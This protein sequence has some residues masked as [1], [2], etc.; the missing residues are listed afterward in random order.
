MTKPKIDILECTLRDG[1]YL[2]DYQFTA[3]D[4]ALIGASLEAAGFRF[5]E[6]G[7][8]LGFRG[9]SPQYGIAAASDEEYLS[10]AQQ[11]FRKAKFGM[12]CIPGI[13]HLKDLDKAFK[14][15]MGFVRVG[16]NVTEARAAEP[17][18]KKAKDFGLLTFSNL[19]KSYALSPAEFAKQVQLVA[20]Y[21]AD[22]I[23]VV[24]SAGGMLPDQVK[25]YVRVIKKESAARAGF[26]GH[27]NLSLGIANSLAAVEA[28]ADFIDA[29]IRGIGRSAGNTQTEIILMVLEKLGYQTGVNINRT[30][31]IG[32]K[33]IGPMIKGEKGI[34][35]DSAMLGWTLF[36]SGFMSIITKYAQKYQLD[37]KELLKKVSDVERVTVTDEI[38]ERMAKTLKP[39]KATLSYRRLPI[40]TVEYRPSCKPQD[41]A[42]RV[43]RISEDM[44]ALA[45]KTCKQTVFTIAQTRNPQKPFTT[46]PFIREGE[47][48]IIGNAEVISKRDALKIIHKIDGRCD[49][50][51]L[52][53]PIYPLR[54]KIAKK[55][56]CY[57][58]YDDAGAQ[59]NSLW[60]MI[61][62][63]S[64]KS[65][66]HIYVIGEND[67]TRRF[68]FG[69]NGLQ[70]EIGTSLS[71]ADFLVGL[72]PYEGSIGE[73]EV[74]QLKSEATIIDAGPGSMSIKAVALALRRRMKIYRLDMR[75]GLFGEIEAVLQTQ[76]L[77]SRVAGEKKMKGI[78]VVAGG[79]MGRRGDIV[80]DSVSSP[81]RIIGI[82]DGQ[83]GILSVES[84]QDFSAQLKKI[85]RALAESRWD[86]VRENS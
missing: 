57:C 64:V 62:A 15:R 24:D 6:I 19:M 66:A 37:E 41:I 32:E 52:D 86:S 11:V 68:H 34:D 18:I 7:H 35:A 9:S 26:H 49:F 79:V 59:I 38:V 10:A 28:G 78:R 74:R 67:L 58:P 53:M 30:L 12:F 43:T 42:A 4:T 36:H 29:S 8:G 45:K 82:A 55:Q 63:I 46:F 16:T 40:G 65:P 77:L 70:Y 51:F 20:R 14:H 31:D 1:S 2:I 69:A 72:T 83:G 17:F 23:C 80:V 56:S 75:A 25:E 39:K 54:Q 73:N 85:K 81:R 33:I 71:R 48:A 60:K 21:G 5:I 3:E 44:L 76:R 27:N 50:I 22:V 13:A 84:E 47:T 61:A